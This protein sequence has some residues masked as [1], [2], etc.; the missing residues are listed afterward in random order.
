M[1]APTQRPEVVRS[2]LWFIP[3]PLF[4]SRLVLYMIAYWP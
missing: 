4:V 3:V 2:F 1:M